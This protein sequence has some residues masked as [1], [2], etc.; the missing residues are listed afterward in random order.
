M[1][2]SASTRRTART[3][4]ALQAPSLTLRSLRPVPTSPLLARL[5]FAPTR[6]S[7][8]LKKLARLSFTLVEVSLSFDICSLAVCVYIAGLT[9]SPLLLG[10]SNVFSMPS[11]QSDAVSKYFKT[12]APAYT[13]AQYNNSQATRGYPDVAANGANYNVFINGAA[14]LVYGTSASAPVFASI[15]TMVNDARLAVGKKPVGFINPSIY[16]NAFKKAFNDIHIGGN[17]GCG[18]PGFTAVPGW[19]P[20]TGLGTP[21][22]PNLVAAFLLLP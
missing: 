2:E 7:I 1:A 17:Q 14:G 12:H 5:R 21:N 8:L 18:T 6:M 9:V 11:Y 19:D 4:L 16:S 15:L 20:V 10:F 22:Y 3:P 13:A